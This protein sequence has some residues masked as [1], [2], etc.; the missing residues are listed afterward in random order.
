VIERVGFYALK[1]PQNRFP[2]IGGRLTRFFSEAPCYDPEDMNA[3]AWSLGNGQ[4]TYIKAE[5]SYC[6]DLV[7]LLKGWNTFFSG[8]QR[9]D[10]ALSQG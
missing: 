1:L 3:V 7:P 5:R 4:D 8:E 10:P 2:A 9:Q 6:G